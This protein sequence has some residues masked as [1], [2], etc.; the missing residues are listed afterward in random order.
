MIGAQ[1]PGQPHFVINQPRT[2]G[3]EAR[4]KFD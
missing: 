2:I 3:V 1:I 4:L